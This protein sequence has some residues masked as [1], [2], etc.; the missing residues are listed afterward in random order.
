[1]VAL[2][3]LLAACAAALLGSAAP[4]TS[5]HVLHEQRRSPDRQWK[6]ST[7]VAGSAVLP[8]RIGLTQRNLDKGPGLLMEL[9]HPSSPK[10]GQYLSASEVH[11]LFAPAQEGVSFVKEWLTSFGIESSRIVQ[12]DNKGWLA[13]DALASEVEAMFDTEFYEYSLGDTGKL[14]IGCDEYVLKLSRS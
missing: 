14:R 1:M 6:R 3:Y 13:F 8:M 2:Q 10:Y 9:S 12:S 4:T 5:S 11:D 7:R